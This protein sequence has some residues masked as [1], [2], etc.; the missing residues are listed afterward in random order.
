ME[1]LCFTP[2]HRRGG[3]R[4][5]FKRQPTDTQ[6]PL[7]L[8]SGLSRKLLWAGLWLETWKAEFCKWKLFQSEDLSAAAVSRWHLRGLGPPFP[9]APWICFLLPASLLRDRDPWQQHWHQLSAAGGW[10]KQREVALTSHTKTT[11]AKASRGADFPEPE[12][13]RQC[14]HTPSATRIASCFLFQREGW[15]EG[16]PLPYCLCLLVHP[17]C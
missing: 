10:R 3:I 7:L 16:D 15:A 8:L 9:S 4:S 6:R 1:L 13:P 17:V 11:T 12:Y 14:Q 5:P 2:V